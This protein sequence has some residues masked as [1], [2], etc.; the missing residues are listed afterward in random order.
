MMAVVSLLI[1]R[2]RWLLL[3]ALAFLAF[4]AFKIHSM[5]Q[6][7]TV[8]VLSPFLLGTGLILM[9]QSYESGWWLYWLGES[10][11]IAMFTSNSMAGMARTP[12]LYV[13]IGITSA[14]A[15][16]WFRGKVWNYGIVLGLELFLAIFIAMAFPIMEMVLE[17]VLNDKLK[18]VG[19]KVRAHHVQMEKYYQAKAKGER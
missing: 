5:T 8:E 19:D 18:K 7:G 14:L 4:I 6:S 17:A 3:P 2:Y 16:L 13:I 12:T 11:V 10:L 1:V 9:H 15:A